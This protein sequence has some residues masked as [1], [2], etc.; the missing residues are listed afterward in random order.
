MQLTAIFFAAITSCPN[1][2]QQDIIAME[3]ETL[4]AEMI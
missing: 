4:V 3:N 2:I 1:L